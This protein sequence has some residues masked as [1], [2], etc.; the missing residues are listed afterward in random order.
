MLEAQNS[1]G[2]VSAS[3]KEPIKESPSGKEACETQVSSEVGKTCSSV[4]QLSENP[5]SE[6]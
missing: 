1:Q 5:P 6:T 3:Y 4:V 2:H